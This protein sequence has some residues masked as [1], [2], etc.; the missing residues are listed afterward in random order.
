MK[1]CDRRYC[2]VVLYYRTYV[3]PPAQDEG[4]YCT[5]ELCYRTVNGAILLYYYYFYYYT[6]LYYSIQ[7][8]K[9]WHYVVPCYCNTLLYSVLLYYTSL[10]ARVES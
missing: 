8:P 7:V 1:D 10:P 6:I 3:H 4:L 9:L 2:T 5:V